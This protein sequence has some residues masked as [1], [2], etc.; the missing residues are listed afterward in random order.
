[1]AGVAEM[2]WKRCERGD[3]VAFDPA[4]RIATTLRWRPSALFLIACE[5]WDEGLAPDKEDEPDIGTLI[6]GEPFGK[7]APRVR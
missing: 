3:V 5:E 1:M 2:T 6:A 7:D 4:V